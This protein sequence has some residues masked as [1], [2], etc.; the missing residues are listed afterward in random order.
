VPAAVAHARM[1][2]HAAKRRHGC[3]AGTPIGMLSEGGARAA[4]A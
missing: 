2:A 3:E 1:V 4:E